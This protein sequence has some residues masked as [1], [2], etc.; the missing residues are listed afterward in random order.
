MYIFEHN[1]KIKTLLELYEDKSN[2]INKF[3]VESLPNIIKNNDDY[4]FES[5]KIHIDYLSGMNSKQTIR[6][7]LMDKDYNIVS[8]NDYHIT[9]LLYSGYL[10]AVNL[11]KYAMSGQIIPD[12]II[13]LE[14]INIE[15]FDYENFSYVIEDDFD[16]LQ[17]I[18]EA[19][20]EYFKEKI[21]V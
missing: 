10:V 17:K 9:Y 13:D 11:A 14:N 12:Y 20:S 16:K 19:I 7:I 8:D 21:R 1:V 18:Y 3:L 15:T 4:Y 5:K 6:Y 2:D